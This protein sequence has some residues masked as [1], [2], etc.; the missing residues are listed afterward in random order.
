[1]VQSMAAAHSA[2]I[3]MG[4]NYADLEEV[5]SE[6]IE[7]E[8]FELE[9]EEYD[10]EDEVPCAQIT[11]EQ[12]QTVQAWLADRSNFVKMK[13]IGTGFHEGGGKFVPILGD[14]NCMFRA[15]ST[16]VTASKNNPNGTP[17]KHDEI[18]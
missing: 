17:D 4:M 3:N 16:F 11:D 12:K 13:S 2:M 10:S 18:R 7:F 5:K 9:D 6:P 14:G 1:M 15:I 8:E